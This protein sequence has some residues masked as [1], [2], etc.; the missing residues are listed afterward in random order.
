VY[1]QYGGFP[2]WG[3]PTSSILSILFPW[4]FHE[5]VQLL[6]IM[7]THRIHVCYIW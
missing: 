1:P 6:G 7:I 3:Y 2:K 4:I 5:T